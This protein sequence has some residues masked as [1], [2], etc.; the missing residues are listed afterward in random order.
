M[1]LEQPLIG[2]VT[3]CGSRGFV[4]AKRL[5]ETDLPV[6]GGFCKAEAQRGLIQVIGVIYDISIHDDEFARQMAISDQLQPEQEE[7][8]K[9]RLVPVEVSALS[10]GYQSQAELRYGLPPQP[11]ISMSPIYKLTDQEV[12]DFT[13]QLDF[14]PVILS[15]SQIPVEDLL[16]ACLLRAVQTRSGPDQQAF[17]LNAGRVCA[18]FLEGDLVR[19]E[20][21]L[22]RLK[23]AKE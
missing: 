12:R 5:P 16:V 1:A 6:F 22:Y 18:R 15:A 17:L 4:G 14:V 20:R 11:P 21:I 2:L 19:L 23:Q 7:D 10:I 9:A 8:Q 3:R 13:H